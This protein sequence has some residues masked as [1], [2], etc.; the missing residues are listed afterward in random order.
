MIGRLGLAD[1][2]FIQFG[3]HANSFSVE[4]FDQGDVTV[5]LQTG[6]SIQHL[7]LEAKE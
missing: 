4:I 5:D 1:I 2:I 7:I 3:W 6:I